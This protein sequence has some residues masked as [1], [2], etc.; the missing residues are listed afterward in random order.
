MVVLI[1]R[2][3]GQKGRARSSTYQLPLVQRNKKRPKSVSVF[4]DIDTGCAVLRY[5]R[6]AGQKLLSGTCCQNCVV[7]NHSTDG[8]GGACAPY[9]R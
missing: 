9:T 4:N 8:A 7:V 5:S 6:S 1:R 2:V 3:R